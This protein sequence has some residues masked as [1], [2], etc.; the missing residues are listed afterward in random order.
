[1]SLPHS[2]PTPSSHLCLYVA[3]LSNTANADSIKSSLAAIAWLHKLKDLPDPTKAFSI[4]RTLK[5]L[6][7]LGPAHTHKFK[8]V[9]YRYLLN[10]L[11]VLPG[12]TSTEYEAVLFKAVFLLAYYACLRPGEYANSNGLTHTLKVENLEVYPWSSSYKLMITLPSY[13]HSKGSESFC[14]EPTGDTKVCPVEAIIAFLRRRPPL[15]GPLFIHLNHK[16]I[17]R[18]AVSKILRRAATAAGYDPQDFSPHSLRVGRA[19]DLA[20]DGVPE[21]I[22]KKTGRWNSNAYLQYLR[23]ELFHLPPAPM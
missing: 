4:T 9:R 20:W 3:Y 16:P 17:A 22:I 19:T 11:T 21:H 23:F 6:E 10:F 7:K 2:L 1:M 13:K 8:P 18:A 12:I 5:G 14:L 15:T